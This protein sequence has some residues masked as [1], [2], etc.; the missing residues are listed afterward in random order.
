MR[1]MQTTGNEVAVAVRRRRRRH[2]RD[3]MEGKLIG[4]GN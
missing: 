3:N 2:A 4:P 1:R